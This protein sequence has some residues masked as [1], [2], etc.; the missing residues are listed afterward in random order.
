MRRRGGNCPNTIEVL[1][2]FL[3]VQKDAVISVNLLAVLPR[4]SSLVVQEIQRSLGPNVSTTTCLYRDANLEPA[5]S[6]IIKNLATDSRT[7]INY[8][9]LPEM[10]CDEFI[11]VADSLGR[12]VTWYH[13]EVSLIP[14]WDR[15]T[16]KSC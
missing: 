8:N 16:N 6:Y 12:G 15:L 1:Q 2:Q 11:R 5:S 13:F 4:R 14:L 9:A 10:T 7:I 3:D